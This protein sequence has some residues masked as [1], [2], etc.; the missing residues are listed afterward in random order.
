ML[1]PPDDTDIVRGLICFYLNVYKTDEAE[2]LCE[3]YLNMSEELYGR[4]DHRCSQPLRFYGIL[5]HRQK[6]FLEAVDFLEEAYSNW[7]S[8]FGPVHPDVQRVTNDLVE[9]LNDSQQHG[10]AEQFAEQNYDNAVTF[11]PEPNHLT[12][13]D[14]AWS[15]ARVLIENNSDLGKADEL[16]QKALTIRLNLL[17]A[18]ATR[19][20]EILCSIVQLHLKTNCVTEDDRTRIAQACSNFSKA[21]GDSHPDAIKANALRAELETRMRS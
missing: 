12:V 7:S 3:R 16:L 15:Y 5:R 10:R 2:P 19:V 17:G 21:W 13:S 1:A 11:S 6:R 8:H 14:S 9:A 20:A 18:E 4:G